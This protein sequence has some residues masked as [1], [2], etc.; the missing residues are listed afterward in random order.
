MPTDT[1]TTDIKSTESSV[2][3]EDYSFETIPDGT[4]TVTVEKDH[5]APVETEVT[6]SGSD[7]DVP[8]VDL[9]MWGD[10]N[11]DANINIMDAMAVIQHINGVNDLSDRTQA[12]A[13]RDSAGINI[14]DAMAIIQHINGVT[15][16]TE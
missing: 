10:A 11:Q 1:T 7:V 14:M 2:S 9:Y 5:F 4:Y 16:I 12:N 15:D 13:N 8:T 3:H 6:V